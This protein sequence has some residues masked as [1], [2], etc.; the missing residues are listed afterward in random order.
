MS[1]SLARDVSVPGCELR[2]EPRTRQRH[3]RVELHVLLAVQQHH[4]VELEPGHALHQLQ[5]RRL[6]GDDAERRQ[7]GE[8]GV[9]LVHK[10]EIRRLAHVCVNTN[11]AVSHL[12]GPGRTAQR[13]ER[14]VARRHGE[15]LVAEH[16]PAGLRLPSG[17]PE[18]NG[19]NSSSNNYNKQQ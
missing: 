2:P 1:T 11:C 13:V 19:N 17:Q 4:G 18:N 14:E 12:A 5:Q 15:A 8:R 10:L 3:G 9:A 16:M 7:R 6:R